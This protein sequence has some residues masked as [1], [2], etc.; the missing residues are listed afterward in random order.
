[1]NIKKLFLTM[2][3]VAAIC[4]SAVVCTA[5]A[6]DDV[7]TDDDI[8]AEEDVPITDGIR[9][10]EGYYEC[11][12]VYRDGKDC[13]YDEDG[14]AYS[15]ISGMSGNLK[16]GETRETIEKEMTESVKVQYADIGEPPDD[17]DFDVYVY[18]YDDYD[19]SPQEFL[20]FVSEDSS[21]RRQ[22]SVS[23]NP[24]TG[25]AAPF[26]ALVSALLSAACIAS[27]VGTRKAKCRF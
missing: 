6:E 8:I 19:L 3:I 12:V 13:I 17:S 27:L 21:S 20:D 5:F 25:T 11:I 26:A 9:R 10:G 16:E 7:P 23:A 22:N 2:P 18:F 24:S 14:N 4:L 1:M 15:L